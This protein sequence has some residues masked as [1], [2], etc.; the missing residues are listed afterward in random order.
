[1]GKEELKVALKGILEKELPD[2]YYNAIEF[3]SNQTK[4]ERLSSNKQI[5]IQ[6]CKE[7]IHLCFLVLRGIID[8]NWEILEEL[9]E[10]IEEYSQEYEII[11]NDEVE[12]TKIFTPT[13]LYNLLD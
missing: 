5:G 4:F 3:D 9:E 7:D 1:M 6:A 2:N 12:Y 11:V 8:N 13:S 10:T